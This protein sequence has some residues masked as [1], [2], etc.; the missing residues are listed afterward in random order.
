M[1]AARVVF[2]VRWRCDLAVSKCHSDAHALPLERLKAALRQ[3][4]KHATMRVNT[5]HHSWRRGFLGTVLRDLARVDILTNV[6]GEEP[7]ERPLVARRK[8]VKCAERR[9]VECAGGR[10]G[11]AGRIIG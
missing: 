11:D 5:C 8:G 7:A 3:L 10:Q 4:P 1:H 2:S 9:K 6:E